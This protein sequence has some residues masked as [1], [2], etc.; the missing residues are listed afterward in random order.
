MI[1]IAKRLTASMSLLNTQSMGPGTLACHLEQCG[2][3]RN[4]TIPKHSVTLVGQALEL[5]QEPPGPTQSH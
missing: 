1:P 4:A 3:F 5:S 2:T